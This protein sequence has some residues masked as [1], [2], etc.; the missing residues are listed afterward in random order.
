MKNA[1]AQFKSAVRKWLNSQS[2]YSVEEFLMFKNDWRGWGSSSIH[3]NP[4]HSNT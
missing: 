4:K 2:F 3:F 1:K